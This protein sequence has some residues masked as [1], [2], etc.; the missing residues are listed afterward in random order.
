MGQSLSFD[1]NNVAGY[2]LDGMADVRE[3]VVG[4][5][6]NGDGDMTDTVNWHVF[7]IKKS[8]PGTADMTVDSIFNY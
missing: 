2:Y 3:A 4:I 1:D 5:D 8:S 7:L 6:L